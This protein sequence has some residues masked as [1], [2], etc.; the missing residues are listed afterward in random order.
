MESVINDLENENEMKQA[1]QKSH[2]L[3]TACRMMYYLILLFINSYRKKSWPTIIALYHLL[4]KKVTDASN[5][6]G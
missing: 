4:Y 2:T 1:I 3:Y 5:H 6:A